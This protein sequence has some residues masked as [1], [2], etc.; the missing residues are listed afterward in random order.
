MDDNP[1]DG[2]GRDDPGRALEELCSRIVTR[3]H[4]Y[5]HLTLPLIGAEL[6]RLTESAVAPAGS[7]AD[8]RAAF[9]HLAYQLQR[10]L[11]KEEN[12]LFPALEAMAKANREGGPRPALPFPTVMHPIR[13]ME[14][15]HAGIATAMDHLREISRGF[16]A[17][18]DA[19]DDWRLC[20][21][22]LAHLEADLK[23]HFRM[24]DEE[25]FP[26]AL[27]LERRLP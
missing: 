27:D 1:L 25:L 11:A 7:L 23:V 24:E 17:S 12:V 20:L 26:C 10:H 14:N 22:A 15:E 6:A 13:L 5:L 3:H 19:P 21:A 4:A 9:T 16:V 2:E 18:D 8:I